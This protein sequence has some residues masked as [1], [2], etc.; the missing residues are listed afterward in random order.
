MFYKII[1][2]PVCVNFFSGFAHGFYYEV[3]F[4]QNF[5]NCLLGIVFY[6]PHISKFWYKLDFVTGQ[7]PTVWQ[8]DQPFLW[9]DYEVTTLCGSGS[10]WIGIFLPESML[11]RIYAVKPGNFVTKHNLVTITKIFSWAILGCFQG[12]SD[13]NFLVKVNCQWNNFHQFKVLLWGNT[14]T[15]LIGDLGLGIL[16]W[17]LILKSLNGLIKFTRTD[18]KFR[19]AKTSF[20]TNFVIS[21]V[22]Y[23]NPDL[24][25]PHVFGPPGSGSGSIS[26]RYGSGSCSGS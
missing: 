20:S 21:S 11:I 12:S 22:A 2:L 26:Q 23:P 15:S 7:V 3:N 13:I 5:Q 18:S 10:G 17:N 8:S 4:Q 25:D 9:W 19:V 24:P 6:Y 14:F 16:W 1:H